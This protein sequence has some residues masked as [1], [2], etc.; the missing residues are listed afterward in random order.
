MMTR[1]NGKRLAVLTHPVAPPADADVSAGGVRYACAIAGR[2]PDWGLLQDDGF[3]PDR[4]PVDLTS[5][6]SILK[7]S[8]G[9]S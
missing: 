6:G 8:I 9:R 3:S 4:N 7:S 1:P 5:R 2:P